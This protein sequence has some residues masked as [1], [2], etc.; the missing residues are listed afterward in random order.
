MENVLLSD[1]EQLAMQLSS[2]DQLLLL[3]HL[4]QQVHAGSSENGRK[5]LAGIWNGRFPADFDVD[6]ALAEVRSE[7][8]SGDER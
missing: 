5:D 6:A 2:S 3:E 1:I 8:Q 7:G 4:A